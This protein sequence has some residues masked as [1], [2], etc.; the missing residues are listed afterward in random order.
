M[1]HKKLFSL[2]LV[3]VTVFSL[4]LATFA[5]DDEDP[6]VLQLANLADGD[7]VE[8]ELSEDV[9]T[10]LYVFNGNEGD[11]VTIE[12]TAIDEE[13]DPLLIVLS[14]AGDL[15]AMNDDIEEGN[16]NASLEDIELPETGSY[17]IIAGTV[18][19]MQ[20][21]DFEG[22]ELAFELTIEGNSEVEELGEDFV[23]YGNELL[24]GEA[25]TGETDED[26]AGYF[27]FFQGEEGDVVTLSAT[28]DDFDT[29]LYVF[30]PGGVR[31]AANDD[32]D[33]DN[34]ELNSLVEE[35]ELPEDGIYLVMVSNIFAL[36]FGVDNEDASFGEFE[37]ELTFE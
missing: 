6:S 22:D 27:F 8:G 19:A 34:D 13:L 37:V 15:I 29:V 36:Y 3:L 25:Q 12:M 28:S 23:Y 2:L 9:P 30:G 7:T 32:I 18:F 26:A 35:V 33:V 4:N 10:L 11:E 31:V 1:M 24:D 5:Q 16:L 21:N 17:F 20:S 14:A